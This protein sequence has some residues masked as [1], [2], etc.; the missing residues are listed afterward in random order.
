MVF[1]SN[2]GKAPILKAG[3]ISSLSFAK[4]VFLEMVV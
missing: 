1:V 2:S 4:M 3:I